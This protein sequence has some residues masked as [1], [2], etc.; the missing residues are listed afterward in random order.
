MKTTQPWVDQVTAGVRRA[1]KESGLT[2]EH[3]G[4]EAGIP[5]ATLSRCLN[6]HYP[7]NLLQLERM[8]AVIG[9]TPLR[10]LEL[11]DAA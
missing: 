9:C 6:G 11:S 5:N 10:F 4:R 1:I 3:V 8:A 7:L 2:E